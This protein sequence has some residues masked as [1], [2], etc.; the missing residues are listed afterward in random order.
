MGAVGWTSWRCLAIW[1][2]STATASAN[3]SAAV[4]SLGLYPVVPTISVGDSYRGKRV[5]LDGA[6]ALLCGIWPQTGSGRHAIPS[7]LCH[8]V[9]GDDVTAASESPIRTAIRRSA[10]GCGDGD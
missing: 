10:C 6:H 2:L 1:Y 9:S 8:W 3:E 4:C 7:G 5:H